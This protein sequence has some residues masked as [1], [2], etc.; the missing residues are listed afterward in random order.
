[1][2]QLEIENELLRATV[3]SLVADRRKNIEKIE[4]EI[5][6]IESAPRTLCRIFVSIRNKEYRII[7]CSSDNSF[8]EAIKGAIK[9]L[10]V[11]Y[12][13]KINH[14]NLVIVI[15][16]GG[17]YEYCVDVE[18]MARVLDEAIRSIIN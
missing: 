7:S 3:T 15:K 12:R 10:P 14:G 13:E 8:V 9:G 6:L 2:G 11:D 17:G 4:E 1:M 18:P 5:S 16:I